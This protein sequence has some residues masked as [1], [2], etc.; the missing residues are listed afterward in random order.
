M[1]TM[2]LLALTGRVA[3]W[4]NK[5]QEDGI[6]SIS[7]IWRIVQDG[8]SDLGFG[9]DEFAITLPQNE[10]TVAV[11]KALLDG[12]LTLDEIHVL[13]LEVAKATGADLDKTGIRVR[14]EDEAE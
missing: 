9:L 10:L 8:A 13:A 5:A 14:E 4:Y 11:A 12:K 1:N 6:V 7:E 2:K 3:T